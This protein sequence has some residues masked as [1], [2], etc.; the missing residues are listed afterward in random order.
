MTAHSGGVRLP[1]RGDAD[2]AAALLV[3]VAQVPSQSA[4]EPQPRPSPMQRRHARE[5]WQGCDRA[6]P[7]RYVAYSGV[8]I[9]TTIAAGSMEGRAGM[10]YST[11][12]ICGAVV[13][14][15][16]RHRGWHD[17]MDRE[18]KRAKREAQ[19][20]TREARA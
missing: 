16:S 18:I 4:A 3:N 11:C 6:C 17:E 12:N 1:V 9:A 15:I 5:A 14:N 7:S 20:A 10:N 13:D 8:H 2:S 19:R